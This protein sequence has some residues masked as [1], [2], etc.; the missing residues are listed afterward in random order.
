MRIMLA[1]LALGI[2]LGSGAISLG[3]FGISDSLADPGK[4]QQTAT[5]LVNG[6]ADTNDVVNKID[7]LM[8]VATD[9]GVAASG[10]PELAANVAKNRA[11]VRTALTSLLNDPELRRAVRDGVGSVQGKLPGL[12]ASTDPTVNGLSLSRA[13]NT[14]SAAPASNTPVPASAAQVAT[15]APVVAPTTSAA[16]ATQP[17]AAR[18]GT[19]NAFQTFAKNAGLIALALLAVALVVSRNRLALVRKLA[20]I[21]IVVGVLPILGFVILPGVLTH[22]GS[23]GADLAGALHG[24]GADAVTPG[25]VIAL[26]GLGLG[27]ATTS[28]MQ[29]RSMLQLARVTR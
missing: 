25:L 19:A 16:V 9:A 8:G 14:T 10:D 1:T 21:G 6:T 2:G 11:F 22:A 17:V 29:R 18:R 3:S 24:A 5:E 13:L 12:A 23:L 28:I 27:I 26:G 4:V 20:R 15:P 7:S